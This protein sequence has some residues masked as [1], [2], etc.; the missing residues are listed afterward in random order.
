MIARDVVSGESFMRLWNSN[1]PGSFTILARSSTSPYTSLGLWPAVNNSNAGAWGAFHATMQFLI[2]PFAASPEFEVGNT[3]STRPAIASDNR[4]VGRFGPNNNNTDPIVILPPTGPMIIVAEPPTWTELGRSPAISKDGQIVVWAGNRGF[5]PGIF[6][7]NTSTG[8]IIRVAGENIGPTPGVTPCTISLKRTVSNPNACDTNP[9]LGYDAAGTE[10]WLTF[11]QAQM[12]ER[13]GV[14]LQEPAGP[15]ITNGNSFVVLFQGTPSAASVDNS[16]IPGAQPLIFSN[17]PGIFTARVDIDPQLTSPPGGSVMRET[18]ARPVVQIGDSLPGLGSV[19]ALAVLDSLANVELD[20]MGIPRAQKRG[21]HQ[22]AFFA[23]V[24]GTSYLIRAISFDSDA[25]GLLDHWETDGIDIDQDGVMDLNLPA[26]GANPAAR[27]LFLEIDWL[28]DNAG[29]SFRPVAAAIDFVV[30]LFASAPTGPV[31]L[32]VDA[33]SKLSRHMGG[34]PSLLQGGDVITDPAGHINLIHFGVPG[35]IVL[36]P[37]N[38]IRTFMELKDS[39][40]GTA[41]KRAREFAFRYAISGDGAGFDPANPI[42]G[43]GEAAYFS[44]NHSIPGN[45]VLFAL[46]GDRA[47]PPLPTGFYLY[48]SIAH[49]FGHTLGL[50]HGGI[51]HVTT[52]PPLDPRHKPAEYKPDYL[53][54]M[55]YSFDKGLPGRVAASTPTS[56]TVMPP[57]TYEG[58]NGL[59]NL[60][61]LDVINKIFGVPLT[62]DRRTITMN[63]FNSL[64][65]SSMW[66]TNP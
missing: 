24:G 33:G 6:A 50:R 45:D 12:D 38:V 29:R 21:D 60:T 52:L 16:A 63:T 31:T 1:S 43:L 40:F 44:D 3:F 64:M 36:P 56:V 30:N 49:E 19:S 58:I 34:T 59:A 48:Q 23:T 18:S 46:G 4:V 15:G 20:A 2:R 62:G 10:I 54:L 32:H 5:G 51:D 39:H 14:E 57:T 8:E 65:V 61:G 7:M 66:T 26:M 9:D 42:A 28:A 25:D 41:D 11:T 47:R 13:L 27:D 37:P 55:N 17:Q 53:S 22:I 35:S